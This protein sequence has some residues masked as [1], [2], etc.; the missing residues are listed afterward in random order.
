MKLRITVSTKNKDDVVKIAK[1]QQTE[2]VDPKGVDGALGPTTM[3]ILLR[4]G[5]ELSAVKAKA[6]DVQLVFYPGEF[7]DLGAWK[8]ARAKAQAEAKG[9]KEREF[10]MLYNYVPKGHGT[11]YVKHKG[12]VVDSI[13]ARGGPPFTMHD[14]GHT[15]DPSKAGSYKLGAGKSVITKSWATSQIAWGAPIREHDGEIQFKNPGKDW[16]YA[17]GK[18]AVTKDLTREYFLDESGNVVK[19]WRLND[20]GETGFRVEGS[21]GLYIHTGPESEEALKQEVEVQGTDEQHVVHEQMELTH[22]HGCLHVD[23]YDRNRWMRT[24][25]L[26]KGVTITIKKYED[27]LDPK[28]TNKATK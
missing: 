21:P 14:R 13:Q 24:G 16:Q 5:L 2:G 26:Q 7:E 19:E 8:E 27:S 11:I 18:H 22:S 10:E 9:D 15:A 3:A 25:Y 6:G 28:A 20:F 4:N 23:P 17:T 12:N 1:M